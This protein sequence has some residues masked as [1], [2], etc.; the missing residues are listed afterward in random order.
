MKKPPSSAVF[1]DGSKRDRPLAI[2]PDAIGVSYEPHA[3]EDVAKVVNGVAVLCVDG[4]LVHHSS[5]W[6][7]FWETYEDIAERFKAALDCPDVKAVVL[8]FDSPGGE[9]AGLNETVRIM[10]GMKAAAG[11]PVVAYVDEAC[12]SAAYALAMVADEVYLPPSGGVGSI[13]VITV[14]ADCTEADKK[15]GVKVEVIASGAQKTDGHPHVAIS[16][17]ALKR[18]ARRVNELAVQFF[19]LVSDA[20]GL[21]PKVIEGFQAGIFMGEEAVNA[22]LA[23]GVM[24]LAEC[25]TLATDVFGS[26]DKPSDRSAKPVKEPEPMS[27]LLAATKALNEANAQLAAAK[28]DSDRALAAASVVA[29]ERELAKVKKTKTVTTDTHEEEVDDGEPE[30]DDDEDDDSSDGA[31]SDDADEDA[32]ADDDEAAASAHPGDNAKTGLYTKDRLVRLARQITGKK[33]LEEVMGALHGVWLERKRNAKLAARV[34]QMEKDATATKLTA[35]IAKGMKEGKLAPSQRAFAR[36]LSPKA[37][38]ALLDAT[39][40]M[41][42]TADDEHTESKIAGVGPGGITAE[43][44]KIWTKQGFQPSDFP[45]LAAKLNGAKAGANGVS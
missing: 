33:S 31:E 13:G 3:I 27:A 4:P 26:R 1:A 2:H 18:T 39:P 25:L 20:R 23:D 19:D 42:H 9:V 15:A 36:T 21:S 38:K 8:K 28:T 34:E 16:A 32:E 44:A 37:L 40:K 45:A 35:L 41:V 12:Y 43:M 7:C 11:K 29:A 6:W 17:G 22:G 24:S 10:Q 14:M 30:D 5:G